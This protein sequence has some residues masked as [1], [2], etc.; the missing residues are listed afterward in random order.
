ML[1][2]MNM[3]S[4]CNITVI[5]LLTSSLFDNQFTEEGKEQLRKAREERDPQFV[6]LEEFYV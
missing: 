4:I 2:L 5:S 3:V 1:T 6:K